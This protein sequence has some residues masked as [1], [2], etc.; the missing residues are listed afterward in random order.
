MPPSSGKLVA[1][2]AAALIAGA[3]GAGVAAVVVDGHGS[4]TAATAATPATS[5]STRAVS[6]TDSTA[7]QVYEGAKE[8]VAF[9]S[10]ELSQGTATG[11]GFVVSADGKIVTNE[12]VVDGAQKVTVKLGTAGKEYPA[13][14]L[15]A[16]ASKDL[17]LLKIDATNLKPLQFGD[18]KSLEVGDNV[19]AIGNPFGL[20]NTLT[21]GIVSALGRDIQAPDGTPIA[22]AIQ[23]D[24][25][26][27][28]GNS[29]GALLDADGKVM[30]VNSQ[31]ASAGASSGGEAGNVGIGFAIPSDTVKAFVEHPT[32]SSGQSG[33]AQQEQ[34]LQQD[35]GQGQQVDPQQLDP[36]Q[37]DPQQVDPQQVDPSQQADPY[38][39]GQQDQQQQDVP[40]LVLPGGGW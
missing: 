14:V 20:D 4:S 5:G 39:Y 35:Q 18:S 38:G 25:A 30:G 15:A 29:G 16:D 37:L 23:T 6:N 36:Q 13:Q 33:Q 12:H 11:S 22:G 26:L 21:S 2:G 8:S 31:I 1:L 3:G 9:I 7:K 10:S 32:S 40:Q 24:A 34:Q 17:A 19:Y 28:P 27:N